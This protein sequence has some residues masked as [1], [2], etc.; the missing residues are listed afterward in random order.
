MPAVRFA[1]LKIETRN[2]ARFSKHFGETTSRNQQ[3]PKEGQRPFP[4]AV[5]RRGRG[6]AQTLST[7]APTAKQTTPPPSQRVAFPIEEENLDNGYLKIPSDGRT[8]RLG[9]S[10]GSSALTFIWL[11][12]LTRVVND[13][14]VVFDG[15]GVP[16]VSAA[17]D[18]GDAQYRYLN[19]V[20]ADRG[21]GGIWPDIGGKVFEQKC[22]FLFTSLGDK[23]ADRGIKEAGRFADL[24]IVT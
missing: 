5:S 24:E 23:D 17:E 14:D 3:T 19:R 1:D 8:N 11:T 22:L 13:A 4:P 21:D 7:Y 12:A 20:L 10:P 16:L 2:T 6:R 18:G 15:Q 9:P